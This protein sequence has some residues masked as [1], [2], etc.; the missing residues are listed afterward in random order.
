MDERLRFVARVLDA[1]DVA[2][3]HRAGHAQT[4]AGIEQA[5]DLRS[6][7]RPLLDLVEAPVV[8]V[9][10]AVRLLVEV[11]VIGL[12]IGH[13]STSPCKAGCGARW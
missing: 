13:I 5:V 4:V 3:E 10:R 9:D 12:R 6:V 7:P 1:I 8:H 2:L 11:N